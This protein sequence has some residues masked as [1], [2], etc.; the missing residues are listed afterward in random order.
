MSEREGQ[1]SEG[2][3]KTGKRW[4]VRGVGRNPISRKEGERDEERRGQTRRK[5]REK[6]REKRKA[7]EQRGREVSEKKRK[8]EEGSDRVEKRIE[9]RE[10]ADA[11]IASHCAPGKFPPLKIRETE[12]KRSDD[13]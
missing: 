9:E 5:E 6:R 8:N 12:P 7:R 4:V 1:K 10:R 2:E 13:F 11:Q 3:D